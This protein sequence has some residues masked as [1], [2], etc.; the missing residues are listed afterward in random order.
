MAKPEKN[1]EEKK[2]VVEPVLIDIEEIKQQRDIID[3][4][5][6]PN[7]SHESEELLG[8]PILQNNQS[9]GM[10]QIEEELEEGQLR[11]S[12]EIPILQQAEPSIQ[13]AIK[14]S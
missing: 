5:E 1:N 13:K 2:D 4:I 7:K 14:L 10:S 11:E 3:T 8:L 12:Q 9:Q 6:T